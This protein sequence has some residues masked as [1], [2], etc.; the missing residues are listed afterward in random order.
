[1]Q[2]GV[3]YDYYPA[4]FLVKVVGGGIKKQKSEIEDIKLFS[5]NAFSAVLAFMHAQMIK[6]YLTTREAEL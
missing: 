3:L 2:D 1:M 5:L 6:D 4:F